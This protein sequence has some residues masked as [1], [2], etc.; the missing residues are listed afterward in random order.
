ML[1]SPHL[2]AQNSAATDLMMIFWHFAKPNQIFFKAK[3]HNGDA[4]KNKLLNSNGA[5]GGVEF[6]MKLWGAPLVRS[7]SKDILRILR[8][9][10]FQ[11][12]LLTFL[13]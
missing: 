2:Q 4:I 10:C 11:S 8:L 9:F 12:F 1:R 13:P 7:L 6:R 3:L 5:L